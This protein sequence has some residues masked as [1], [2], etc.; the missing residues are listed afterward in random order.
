MAFL[1]QQNPTYR[2]PL[3]LSLPVDDGKREKSTFTAIFRRLR[4]SRIEEISKQARSAQYGKE[5]EAE[6]P[7]D[8]DVV[9]EI[10]AGWDDVIDDERE[11]VPFTDSAL[12]QMLEIPTV[13]G[14]IIAQWF[15]SLEPAKKKPTGNR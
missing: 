8:R 12:S 6:L 9:R 2:W 15:E 3:T 10:M 1:I 4:Q 14:Q 7:S 11:P 5:D 13:S